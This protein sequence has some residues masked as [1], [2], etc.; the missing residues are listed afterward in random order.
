MIDDSETECQVINCLG[1]HH[2]R[3]QDHF[4][5]V[6]SLKDFS[7]VC[8]FGLGQSPARLSC[9]TLPR[10]S[11]KRQVTTSGRRALNLKE[12][13][14]NWEWGWNC[15]CAYDTEKERSGNSSTL[16]TLTSIKCHRCQ[17][18]IFGQPRYFLCDYISAYNESE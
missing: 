16:G 7:S 13:Q 8:L 6:P 11:E 18:V 12:K 17:W 9:V 1:S 3:H 10:P 2:G 5:L 15:M 14:Q 4:S